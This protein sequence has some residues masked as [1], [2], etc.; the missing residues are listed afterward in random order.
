MKDSAPLDRFTKAI[1][2]HFLS[3]G[4]ARLSG[5]GTEQRYS[6]CPAHEDEKASLSFAEGDN[7]S[8]VF[9]CHTGCKNED[10][11]EALGLS[12]GALFDG[13]ADTKA[14][15][16]KQ[17]PAKGS[18]SGPPPN[19]LIGNGQMV[20]TYMDENGNPLHREIRVTRR[21]GKKKV[22]QRWQERNTRWGWKPGLKNVR[23]VPFNLPAIVANPERTV[24][25][26]EGPWNAV[27][28][29][30]LADQVGHEATFTA[31]ANGA[32]GWGIEY[33]TDFLKA[34]VS[35]VVIIPD[36][37]EPGEKFAEQAAAD[38]YAVGIEV[39]VIDLT[40]GDLD[41]ESV[42]DEHDDIVDWIRKYKQKEF[43]QSAET[44][45]GW[46]LIEIEE[47]EPW[48]D[49]KDQTKEI[50][51]MIEE[52]K[53]R[54]YDWV[55]PDLFEKGDRLLITGGEG[56]GKSTL[57]YQIAACSAAGVHPFASNSSETFAPARSL[58]IDLENSEG[59]VARGL[60]PIRAQ[61]GDRLATGMMYVETPGE[62]IDI[63]TD[64]GALW[65]ERKV[66]RY[67]PNGGVLVIGPLYKM[68]LNDSNSDQD[69][70]KV[71]DVLD[72]LRIKYGLALVIEAH[73]KHP[74]ERS[75]TVYRPFGSRHWIRWPEFG[76]HLSSGGIWTPWRDQRD[77]SRVFPS[78]FKRGI[79]ANGD[80]PW[81]GEVS[82]ED[83]RFRRCLR[84]AMSNWN[85]GDNLPGAKKVHGWL[86]ADTKAWL[87]AAGEPSETVDV[88][89]ALAAN[90][91]KS[92]VE[93]LINPGKPKRAEWEAEFDKANREAVEAR[94]TAETEDGNGRPS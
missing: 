81:M 85:P 15:P 24:F 6:R 70:K 28:G 32:N 63:G 18:D 62:S 51:V 69:A 76:F 90:F 67:L 48:M 35:S 10:V 59:Q 29:Q 11:L 4:S 55:V 21:V 26:V 77:A 27:M 75:N 72:H 57:N 20:F 3:E 52:R 93:A 68:G 17:R 47:T 14:Q 79:L 50:G 66:A 78:R 92:K 49:S 31:V 7:Q 91:T 37:D 94:K 41:P 13:N 64:E 12:W 40:S 9:T 33:A 53:D 23:K 86:R 19:H 34:G 38:L 36:L 22:T 2:G 43:D 88:E 1:V 54:E 44:L 42:L 39:K 71:S 74:G 46:L 87:E 82:D 8:V 80:M 58:L 89:K 25:L 45:F 65:L 30:T 5:Q 61:L 73:T 83:E 56:A 84:V 16:K 60:A